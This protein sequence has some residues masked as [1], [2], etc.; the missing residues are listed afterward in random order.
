M[1]RLDGARSLSRLLSL[2]L[3]HQLEP[4]D[5]AELQGGAGILL[6]ALMH[7]CCAVYAS[8]ASDT[9]CLEFWMPWVV[10][11]L[12]DLLTCTHSTLAAELLSQVSGQAGARVVCR[13]VVADKQFVE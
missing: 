10:A 9:R 12:V 11:R 4:T 13:T 8:K 2:Q 1:E 3:V 7:M 6:A 5:S